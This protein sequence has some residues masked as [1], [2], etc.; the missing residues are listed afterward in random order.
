ML[1]CALFAACFALA[2][3]TS[4]NQAV[5]RFDAAAVKAP[6]VVAAEYRLT[7]ATALKERYA[8]Q[9]RKLVAE[10]IQ[11]LHGAGP[12]SPISSIPRL[13]KDLDPQYMPDI[14]RTRSER[15]PEALSKKIGTMRSLPT[16]A[17]RAKLVL[18]VVPEIRALPAVAKLS[19]AR[20]L[21]SVSTEGDLGKP[22]LTAVA[23]VLAEAAHET[24]NAGAWI[25]VASLVRYERVS[26]PGAD[27]SLVAADAL[28][29]LRERLQSEAGFSLTALDG[30]Q[31]T[32]AGLRGH[33][34]LL[35]FW[36]TW[37]PP[38]RK[39][40]PDMEKLYRKFESRGLIVLAVSDEKRETVEGFLA[41]TPYS[42]AV[43]LDPDR[44]VHGAFGVE[45]IPKSFLFDREGRMAALAI[46]MR[47]EAQ[48]MELLR[49]AGLE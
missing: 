3:D 23:G 46:D 37:C 21:A 9:S 24:N 5:A 49:R 48:F 32:L 44:K 18:E 13:L 1:S 8:E 16:D 35:N 26:V 20:G 15:P 10:A 11:S 12:I 47:T 43:L 38:C 4:V 41:K 30:K 6:V 40:M 45:G 29:D 42:F 14:D 25:E 34:V 22:A 19:L 39:E 31:Y 7:A 28:L 27:P 33:I 17:D 2:A 36:A